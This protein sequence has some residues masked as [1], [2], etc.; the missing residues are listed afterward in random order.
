MF[1]FSININL[2][3]RD[4][5]KVEEEFNLALR[6]I[7]NEIS[8]EIEWRWRIKAGLQL[9]T[10]R[11]EYLKALRFETTVDGVTANLEGWLPVV[12]EAGL[13]TKSFDMRPGLLKGRERRVIPMGKPS[14]SRGFA[15]VPYGEKSPPWQWAEIKHP[16]G[17]QIH[18]QVQQ[19]VEEE[20][21]PEAF[22][23]LASRF[24][25]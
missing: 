25:I 24:S 6:Q 5:D 18:K 19:E 16:G 2:S 9:N 12:T 10:S 8:E 3:D 22:N 7:K 11:E 23:K 17:V 21:I 1:T 13:T 14:G 15:T 20:L 4:W